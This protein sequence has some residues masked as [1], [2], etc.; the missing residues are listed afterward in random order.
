M[1]GD[2]YTEAA[3]QERI[4][5]TLTRTETKTAGETKRPAASRNVNLL[6]DIQAKMHAGKGI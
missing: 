2:K 1:L 6:V 4:T 3:L 5:G